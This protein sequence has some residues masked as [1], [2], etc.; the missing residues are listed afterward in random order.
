[1]IYK[2]LDIWFLDLGM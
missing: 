1:M 2:A